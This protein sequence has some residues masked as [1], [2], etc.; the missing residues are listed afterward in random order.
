MY[1][2]TVQASDGGVDTPAMEEVTIEIT[3][4]DEPGTV[5]LSTL[6]PQVNVPISATLDDPDNAMVMGTITWQW[7]RGS[8]AI[9]GADRRRKLEH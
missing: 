2:V 4:V 8:S 1:T 9:T 3:N 5:M 7:H 6:R